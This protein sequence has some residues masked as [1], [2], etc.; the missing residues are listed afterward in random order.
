MQFLLVQCYC[1][2]D[3]LVYVILPI[4]LEGPCCSPTGTVGSG[5]AASKYPLGAFLDISRHQSQ[6]F[7]AK[8]S[9]APS[10]ERSQ[11]RQPPIH[12]APLSYLLPCFFFCFPF[13]KQNIRKAEN[14]NCHCFSVSSF[15]VVCFS[16][17]FFASFE[18]HRR[19]YCV[20]LFF[21]NNNFHSGLFHVSE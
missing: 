10:N 11:P 16:L 6:R 13:A 12:Q 2:S 8:Y 20:V 4:L 18:A 17:L 5:T 21:L 3:S 7:S 1:S 14:V 19:W 9:V 15:A